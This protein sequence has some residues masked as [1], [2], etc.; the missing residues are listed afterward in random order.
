MYFIGTCINETAI[1][2]LTRIYT[3]FRDAEKATICISLEWKIDE[4][5][6]LT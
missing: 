3:S 6:I 2:N 5:P 1:K 4:K